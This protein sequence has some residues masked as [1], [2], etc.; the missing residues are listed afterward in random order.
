MLPGGKV[1]LTSGILPRKSLALAD[2][3]VSPGLRR[4]VPSL[5]VG[6]VLVDPAEIRLPKVASL[7][8]GPEVHPPHGAADVE[9]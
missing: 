9:G 1:H 6:P 5:R 2:D 8:D 4:L 3:W 7:G